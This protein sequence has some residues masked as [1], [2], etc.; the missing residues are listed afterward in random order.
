[1]QERQSSV[2]HTNFI[3]EDKKWNVNFTMGQMITM[4][5][6]KV[7]QVPKNDEEEADQDEEE[8]KCKAGSS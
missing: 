7:I 1:M 5:L 6:H 2:K 8:I 3:C 4:I